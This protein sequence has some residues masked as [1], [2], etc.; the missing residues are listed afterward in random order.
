VTRLVKAVVSGDPEDARLWVGGGGEFAA[1]YAVLFYHLAA[2]DFYGK[3][4][5]AFLTQLGAP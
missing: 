3:E 5:G 1:A 2:V 4:H